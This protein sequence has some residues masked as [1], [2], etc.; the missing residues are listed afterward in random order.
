MYLVQL[1]KYRST[2]VLGKYLK[3]A[4]EC[5][6]NMI[7]QLIKVREQAARK[8]SEKIKKKEKNKSDNLV[9]LILFIF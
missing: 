6:N 1:V 8:I 2:T 4:I 9:L 5:K 3:E 7:R